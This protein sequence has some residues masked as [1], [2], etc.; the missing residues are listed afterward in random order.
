MT[1]GSCT[2]AISRSRP[3]QCGH[4]STSIA[5]ARCMSA[6]QLQAREPLFAPAPSA[7]AL[8]RKRATARPPR[9]SSVNLRDSAD[10]AEPGVAI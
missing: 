3:P 1:T 9:R 6:A 5:N 7:C 10:G 8:A 2:V 4:A